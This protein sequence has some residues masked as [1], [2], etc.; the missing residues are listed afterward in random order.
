MLSVSLFW[1]RGHFKRKFDK[2]LTHN[3]L[4]PCAV[5]ESVHQVGAPP[6]QWAEWEV[7]PEAAARGGAV[8]LADDRE[9]TRR[10]AWNGRNYSCISRRDCCKTNIPG[11]TCLGFKKATFAHFFSPNLFWVFLTGYVLGT[12]LETF[13]LHASRCS[14][15]SVS[16]TLGSSSVL[17][18]WTILY[19]KSG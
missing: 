5:S 14:N 6:A 11:H 4:E 18:S 7:P 2:E 9:A 19:E 13:V 16:W 12:G 15:P 1:G 17:Q 10:G 3:F 8:I